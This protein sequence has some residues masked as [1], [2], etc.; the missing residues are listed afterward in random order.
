[1]AATVTLP[2][3]W[4]A[5]EQSTIDRKDKRIAELEAA[6]RPFADGYRYAKQ[7]GRSDIL[8]N[9]WASGGRATLQ[10]FHRAAELVKD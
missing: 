4:A 3:G 7:V 8:T 1:M 5:V 9:S 2:D 10:D 6:L